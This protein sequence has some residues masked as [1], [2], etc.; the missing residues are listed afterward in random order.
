VK[1]LEEI[2]PGLRR[3]DLVHQVREAIKDLPSPPEG[4]GE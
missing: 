1:V 3:G 4:Q 2:L